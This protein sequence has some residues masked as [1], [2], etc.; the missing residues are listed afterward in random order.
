MRSIS[1]LTVAAPMLLSAVALALTG[2]TAAPEHEGLARVLSMPRAPPS[3]ASSSKPPSFGW[4]TMIDDESAALAAAPNLTEMHLRL[5]LLAAD[6]GGGALPMLDVAAAAVSPTL[7]WELPTGVVAQA[8]AV[9]RVDRVPSGGPAVY[10][11]T[12]SGTDQNA[13]LSLAGLVDA[14][15]LFTVTVSSEGSDSGGAA[16]A[17]HSTPLKFFTGLKDNWDAK[18]I[19]Y[20]HSPHILSSHIFSFLCPFALSFCAFLTI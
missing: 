3:R 19:W 20:P 12:V 14:A 15:T 16:V 17:H 2:A 8:R 18:P 6:S 4:A 5:N 10:T 13:T 7:T 9:I 11:Q 1:P